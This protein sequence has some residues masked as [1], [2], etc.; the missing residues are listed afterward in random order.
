MQS[1]AT[2][3]A[4][5]PPYRAFRFQPRQHDAP[6][7]RIDHRQTPLL[8]VRRMV[9]IHPVND[10]VARW[11]GQAAEEIRDRTLGLSRGGLKRCWPSLVRSSSSRLLRPQVEA[12]G[13]SRDIVSQRPRS[14]S[15][16]QQPIRQE[17]AETS[18]EQI[19]S[20]SM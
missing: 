1:E 17:T 15:A 4:S 20:R 11:W 6:E 9:S 16:A 10:L 5:A 7:N 13:I 19:A 8:G 3:V 12:I 2:G 18:L 14:A